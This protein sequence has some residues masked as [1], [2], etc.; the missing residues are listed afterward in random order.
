MGTGGPGT[1][2]VRTVLD[3]FRRCWRP[4][5]GYEAIFKVLI[6]LVGAPLFTWLLALLIAASGAKSVT[7]LEV[8]PFFLSSLGAVLALTAGGLFLAMQMA[9]QAG[10]VIIAAGSRAGKRITAWRALLSVVRQAPALVGASLAEMLIILAWAAPL[11][12]VGGLTY[13]AL[14]AVHDIN[15]Y[16]QAWPP[17]FILTVSGL[18][19]LALVVLAALGR[20]FVLWTFVV[21]VCIFERRT[22]F[23]ALQRSAL[24]VRGAFW[25][26]LGVLAAWLATAV[27]LVLLLTA[28]VS[29]PAGLVLAGAG[30][31]GPAN[32]VLV[33]VGG[34]AAIAGSLLCVLAVSPL[35]NI[36]GL[37]LYVGAYDRR[38]WPEPEALCCAAAANRDAGRRRPWP[39]AA[40]LGLAAAVFAAGAAALGCYLQ[41]ALGQPDRV[42]VIA[43]RGDSAQA[44]ENTLSA[45]RRA[46]EL[47]AEIAEIDV[48][49]T[50][51]GVIMVLHDNDLLRVAGTPRGLWQLT[52]AEARRLDVG[53]WYAPEFKGEQLPTLE[54]VLDLARG[55]IRLIIELGAD[56][57]YTNDP[58]ELMALLWRRAARSPNEKLS[59]KFKR[60]LDAVGEM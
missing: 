59:R 44:P 60:L 56:Y 36:V 25:R 37:Q 30:A 33:S 7:N 39:R 3:G 12:A 24:L 6:F 17:V 5:I 27:A 49:E 1:N 15:Y 28:V 41:H 52:C 16:F 43:H 32:L 21:P 42:H 13:L 34:A 14:V 11:L 8:I 54:E 45:L 20:Y 46:I 35:L 47:R 10:L 55:R 51:D 29:A 22:F 50:R 23:Q 19:L 57:I 31:G 38:N 53:S 9:E 18:G 48:Q 40:R 58:A 4:L 26:I 2:A